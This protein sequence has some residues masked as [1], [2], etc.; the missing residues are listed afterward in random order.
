MDETK[1]SYRQ[2]I[3]TTTLFG[4]VQVVTI[5]TNIFRGKIAAVLLGAAGMG[6]LTLLTSVVT[7]IV[8]IASI[9]LNLSAVRDI[10]SAN[11]AKNTPLLSHKVTVFK[12][13][14]CYC[15]IFGAGLMIASS[16]WL[17]KLTF[18]NDQ[19]T[20]SFMWLSLA[21]ALTMLNSS[22]ITFLQG[23]QKLKDMAKSTVLGSLFGLIFSFP[24]FYFYGTKGIV[25]SLV[26]AAVFTYGASTYFSRKNR[27]EQIKI[28]FF[29]TLRDGAEM[30]KLGIAMMLSTL[31]ASA[32]NYIVNSYIGKFGSITEVGL[33]GA[34]I[35]ITNQYVSVIFTAMAV[36][37][38]PRLSAI[39]HDREQVDK[40][41][42]QQAI[43]VVL[44]ITPLLILMILTAPFLINILLSSQFLAITDFV[45][46]V[47]FALLF[48]AASFAFGYIS[49]AK[50]DK[51]TFF[52]F[53]GIGCSLLILGCNIIGYNFGGL[54]GIAI[55]ILISYVIYLFAVN[56]LVSRLYLFRLEMQF[57][58]IFLISMVLLASVLLIALSYSNYYGYSLGILLLLVSFYFSYYELDK[59]IGL[60]AL[61]ISKLRR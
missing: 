20:Y 1:S 17:S 59:R 54:N 56:I 23:T 16:S 10:S 61:I 58:V 5:L 24:L 57:V 7:L 41:V 15:A 12:K 4:G 49:F 36:D 34:G 21:V 47:A 43:I 38:F 33:Y 14:M 52:I 31:I 37:Y 26:I 40:V 48:K 46:W 28:R 45:C 53:E 51:R 60:K 3:K 2:I 44:L 25:P 32:L 42:N 22:N 19:Y 30:A 6:V 50:G 39:C 18:G 8:Q 13:I 27:I 9:G 11:L 35:S 55:S 29:D